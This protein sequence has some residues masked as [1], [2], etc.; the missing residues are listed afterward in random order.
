MFAIVA[1]ATVAAF[2]VYHLARI[3]RADSWVNRE[4]DYRI[5]SEA[6]RESFRQLTL[7]MDALK[8]AAAADDVQRAAEAGSPQARMLEANAR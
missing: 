1:R 3:A 8:V 6:E 4:N 2:D 5:V 7:A